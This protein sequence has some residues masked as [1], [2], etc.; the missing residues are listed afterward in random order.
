MND[1]ELKFNRRFIAAYALLL[2]IGAGIYLGCVTFLPIPKE[3]TR[4][5]DTIVGFIIGTVMSVPIGFFFGS[6]KSSQTKDNTLD[7][8]INSLTGGPP[9]PSLPPP[10]THWGAQLP[11][12]TEVKP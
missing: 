3:N 7:Q 8:T 5:V 4:F 6:S 11:E 10:P 2:T 1:L 9:P 12:K